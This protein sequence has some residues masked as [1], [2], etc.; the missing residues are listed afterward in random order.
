MAVDFNII[1]IEIKGQIE[2]YKKNKSDKLKTGIILQRTYEVNIRFVI[3]I[4]KANR[5]QKY[6]LSVTN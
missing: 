1:L 2:C 6:N 3:T 4:L 5:Y